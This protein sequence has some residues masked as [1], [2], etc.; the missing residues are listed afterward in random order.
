MTDERM[1]LIELIEEGADAD[2]VREL[3]AFAAKRLMELEVEAKT[4]MPTGVRSADRLTQRRY[5]DVRGGIGPPRETDMDQVQD[6]GVAA[7]LVAIELSKATWLLA[8][9]D[10]VIGKVSR[11]RVE[12]GDAS[13]LIEVIER[14]RRSAEA[15][16]RAAIEI[17]C[18]F[19]AGYDGF[20][21]Q[22]RLARGGI[23]C[24]VMDP[25]SLKVDRRARRVKTDRVDAECLLRALQ[26][27]SAF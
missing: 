19:E 2:L 25:S 27:G 20:W 1:A 7:V 14:V 17:E 10:P 6:S 24:R 4:G 21:L 5:H 11:R 13:A 3:L 12:G 16:S 8:I 23:A 15:R 9:H 26:N 18:V 22:R